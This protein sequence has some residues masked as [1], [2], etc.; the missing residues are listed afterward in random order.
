MALQQADAA[1]ALGC[2]VLLLGQIITAP[3]L[4][5]DGTTTAGD[6]DA[7]PRPN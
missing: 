3:R 7:T 5:A 4:L 1:A 6:R 2:A